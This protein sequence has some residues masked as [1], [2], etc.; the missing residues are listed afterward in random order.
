MTTPSIT[1]REAESAELNRIEELL[2][3]NGLPSQ[4]VREKPS[5]FFVGREDAEFVG[6]GGVE[7]HGSNG[8]LRSVVVA[9][10]HRGQ[11]YGTALCDALEDRA[12]TSGIETLYL[13]TTTAAAFFRR[14][15][16]EVID[17]EAVPENVRETTEFAD[18]CPSSATCLRKDLGR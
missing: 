16:Y 15:G 9:E 1:V 13:L 7:P 3:S 6:I 5:C 12:R 18:L 14:R 17:R 4:D 8:L 10:P 11:G 2:E